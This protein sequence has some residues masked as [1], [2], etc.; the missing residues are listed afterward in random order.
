MTSTK[1][2]LAQALKEVS[3][4]PTPTAVKSSFSARFAVR[5]RAP[6]KSELTIRCE[7]YLC[8][9]GILVVLGALAAGG[10][11]S[12]SMLLKFVFV[13]FLGGTS[14]LVVVL[15]FFMNAVE[16]EQQKAVQD[17]HLAVRNLE[18]ARQMLQCRKIFPGEE[19]KGEADQE[20]GWRRVEKE[21]DLQ[22]WA[23]L[24]PSTPHS[25]NSELKNKEPSFIIL[26]SNLLFEFRDEKDAECLGVMCLDRSIV[27]IEV[28]KKN[29]L[30]GERW[31]R[32]NAIKI[33]KLPENKSLTING[34]LE[35]VY[36]YFNSAKQLQTWYLAICRAAKLASKTM[37][38]IAE[39]RTEKQHFGKLKD[40]LLGM[41]SESSETPGPPTGA[42]SGTLTMKEKT[43]ADNDSDAK[44][45]KA[46]NSVAT[47]SNI[48][49]VKHLPVNATWF[50]AMISRL[51]WNFHNTTQL[52]A[53]FRNKLAAKIALIN[54]PSLVEKIEIG[55]L[56]L[57][58]NLP[59]IDNVQL[60]SLD[61][62][63]EVK[64]D[65][66]VRYYGGA[67]LTINIL[68]TVNFVSISVP[69][70]VSATLKSLFGR[71]QFYCGPPPSD[72][73][74]IGFHS[75]PTVELEVHTEIGRHSKI[76][77][78]PT[79]AKI[80]IEKLKSKLIKTMVLPNMDDYV[81]FKDDIPE[82]EPLPAFTR[83]LQVPSPTH[84]PIT[85]SASN[86]VVHAT[87]STSALTTALSETQGPPL[88]GGGSNSLTSLPHIPPLE[89]D[90]R[91]SLRGSSDGS[92]RARSRSLTLEDPLSTST[93]SDNK[94]TSAPIPVPATSSLPSTSE[95]Y[96]RNYYQPKP[97]PI[98]SDVSELAFE[99]GLSPSKDRIGTKSATGSPND[100]PGYLSSL[101]KNFT[102]S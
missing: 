68:I 19:T 100:E 49:V 9:I 11:Q 91:E 85:S 87:Q 42:V 88:R 33:E 36:I 54:P 17:K 58:P 41:T 3:P 99:L 48:I 61:S 60:V 12:F 29:S 102:K 56:V 4:T 38:E 101:W 98:R 23:K 76:V 94:N 86:P 57:G 1:S 64:V 78:F 15:V 27:S 63:G 69:L 21:E 8:C 31:Q 74:W 20:H 46:P 16:K 53:L 89:E 28:T 84:P 47:T 43:V 72:V 97:L 70:T 59:L 73:F 26:K 83:S 80:I 50:N 92:K 13:F 30:R 7:R 18:S 65:A 77:D 71:M 51:F 24:F 34:A 79:L 32:K 93:S 96:L 95:P 82:V 45:K 67:H 22:G 37:E 75:E 66:D 35:I 81:F 52:T 44:N 25:T 6:A 90:T 40:H 55:D 39:E 14:T 10:A 5:P 62:H 2:A